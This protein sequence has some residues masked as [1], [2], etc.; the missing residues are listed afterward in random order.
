[1][2]KQHS[3][4]LISYLKLTWLTLSI[5]G[6]AGGWSWLVNQEHK[7]DSANSQ[8][9]T[10][11]ADAA[12]AGTPLLKTADHADLPEITSADL[13]DNQAPELAQVSRYQAQPKVRTRSSR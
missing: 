1:M 11:V 9:A 8:A 4:Q 7:T 12:D 6:V 3:Q 13:P 10:A 5:S 2:A